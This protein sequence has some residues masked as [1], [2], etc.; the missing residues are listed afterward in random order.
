MLKSAEGGYLIL[1]ST[2]DTIPMVQHIDWT[3]FSYFVTQAI[4]SGEQ[5]SLTSVRWDVSNGCAAPRTVQ[6]ASGKPADTVSP[7]V[8]IKD[9]DRRYIDIDVPCRKCERCLQNRRRL[10]RN[11]M[12]REVQQSNRVWFG[13]ITINPHNRF[14]FSV[15]AGSRDYH[16]SHKEI[17]KEVTKYFKRLRK[18][19]HRFRYVVVAEAHKDGYPH[20]HMLVHEVSAPIPKRVLQDEWPFG[21]TTF[22]LV[23]NLDAVHYV[24]KYL[25]KDARTR[26]RASLRYGQSARDLYSEMLEHLNA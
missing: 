21:F 14:V 19:G 15:R 25:A 6:L 8:T 11:R 16:A 5:P 26:I 17:S 24:A 20:L 12:I 22:K 3:K 2:S 7:V 18:K 23:N 9:G 13:T 10:W 4:A 1:L